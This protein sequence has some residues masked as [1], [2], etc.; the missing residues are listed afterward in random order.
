MNELAGAT[1]VLNRAQLLDVGASATGQ[2]AGD[3]RRDDELLDIGGVEEDFVATY[4]LHYPRLVRAL[5]FTGANRS[6]AEDVAQEAFARTLLRWNRVRRGTNPGGYVYRVAFRLARRASPRKPLLGDEQP[7][8]DVG[9]EAT[10]RVGVDVALKAMPPARRRCAVL[11]LI[12]GLSTRDAARALHIA[13]STVRKQIER[14][15]TDLRQAL[16]D[17]C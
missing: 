17:G 4:K 9:A 7:S 5:E 11:C 8:V 14:A 16:S 10:L 2:A 1:N 15:R 13:E 12:V 3:E 6:N